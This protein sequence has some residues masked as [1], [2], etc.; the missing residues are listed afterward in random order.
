MVP[1]KDPDAIYFPSG[2][3]ATEL[4]WLGMFSIVI[5]IGDHSFNLPVF[6][7]KVLGNSLENSVDSEMS[8]G[9]DGR[10]ER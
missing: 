7:F 4:I 3:H 8:L 5:L 2:D 10:A 1:S 6:T 9:I